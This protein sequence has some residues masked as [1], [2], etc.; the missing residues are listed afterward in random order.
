MKASRKR[1]SAALQRRICRAA[2]QFL[3]YGGKESAGQQTKMSSA[4]DFIESAARIKNQGVFL[5]MK[6]GFFLS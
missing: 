5:S 2:E 1:E 6:A 3:L 4:T